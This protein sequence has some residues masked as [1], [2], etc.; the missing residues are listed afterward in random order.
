MT[1][2]YLEKLAQAINEEFPE[3]RVAPHVNWLLVEEVSEDFDPFNKAVA[4]TPGCDDGNARWIIWCFDRL[5]E[6]GFDSILFV[7]GEQACVAVEC[8]KG[9][10][11]DS[12]HTGYGT[13]CAEAVTRALGKVLGVEE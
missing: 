12:L 5:K 7:W 6:R 11:F 1:P 9:N 13:T 4:Y 8:A 3:W 10:D 2:E